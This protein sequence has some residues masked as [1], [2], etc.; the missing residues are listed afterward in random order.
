MRNVWFLPS[1]DTLLLWARR[2]GFKNPRIVEKNITSREEQ[3]ATEW[4]KYHSLTDFLD[5]NDQN[6]TLEGYPAPLRA[7]L[8][9]EA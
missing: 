6:K 8:I 9:A 3:R 1:C 5:A 7:T 2:V 4:M